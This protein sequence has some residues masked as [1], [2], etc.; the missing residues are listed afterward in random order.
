[1]RVYSHPD[2]NKIILFL[3]I[4]KSVISTADHIIILQVR[5]F[6]NFIFLSL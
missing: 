3:R 4:T 5:I 1:M 6:M 2:E